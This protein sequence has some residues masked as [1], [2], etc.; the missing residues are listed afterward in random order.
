[1]IRVIVYISSSSRASSSAEFLANNVNTL[2]EVAY[3]H[4]CWQ[5]GLPN[6]SGAASMYKHAL[7]PLHCVTRCCSVCA[8]LVLLQVGWAGPAGCSRRR[9]QEAGSVQVKRLA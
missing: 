6:S 7:L 5:T 9:C 2:D 8:L 4:A 3:R 1:M